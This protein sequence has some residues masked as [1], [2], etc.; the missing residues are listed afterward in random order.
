MRR[1][2][3]LVL[4]VATWSWVITGGPAHGSADPP[5]QPADASLF[6]DFNKDGFADLAI[7]VPF[8]DMGAVMDAGAVNVLY[9]SVEGLQATSPDDQLWH[10]D[11]P[12]VRGTA[13]DH[14]FFGSSLATGDFNNDGF[15]DLAIGVPFENIGAEM[16]SGAVNVLYGSAG[17]LQATSPGD[18]LWT[19][20]SPG[21]KDVTEAGDLFGSALITGDFNDDGFADLAIGVPLQEVG[22]GNCCDAGAVNMLYGSAGGLQATSPDDQFWTQNSPGVKGAAEGGELGERFGSSLGA[23]DFNYDGFADLAIGVPREGMGEIG[24]LGAV[25]VLYGSAGGLQATSP[26]DQFWHQDRPGVK[27]A[28]EY[29]DLLGRSLVAGDFNDDGFADLAIGVI[30]EQ[31]GAGCCSGA[32][33]VLYG[34]GGGLQ[35]DSPDD[36]LWTQDS[37]GVKDAAEAGDEFGYSL[38]AGDFNDDGFA[39]LA[40]GV[41][42]EDVR[43]MIAAGAVNVLYGSAGGLQATSPVDQFWHQDRHGVKDAAEAGDLSGWSLMAGNFNDDGSADLAIGVVHEDLGALEDAGAVNVLYASAGGLQADSPDDQFWHQ[44]SPEVKD[45]AKAGDEFGFLDFKVCFLFVFC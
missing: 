40:I 8:E 11:S 13:A 20:D 14:D 37:P 36:Q 22:A 26:D 16:N 24:S 30:A 29:G 33:N 31:V 39:D 19:Q 3:L 34:S 23:G 45:A 1:I 18:Q 15:A 28:A 21:V 12:G 32:V 25:N 44:D 9:G 2:L 41:P 27:D 42:F 35:A 7:G 10:Q 4:M 6:S 17:G 5:G 38:M 43:A